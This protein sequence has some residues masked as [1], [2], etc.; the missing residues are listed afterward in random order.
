MSDH[1][2]DYDDD[3]F[4][5]VRIEKLEAENAALHKKL[6]IARD[7]L[8]RISNAQTTSQPFNVFC[9]YL[10]EHAAEA[11]SKLESKGGGE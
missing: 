2:Y 8:F 11:L 4:E 7:A 10:K 3:Y 6:E 9:N 1:P 5:K